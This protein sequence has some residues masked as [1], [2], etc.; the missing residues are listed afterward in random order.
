MKKWKCVYCGRLLG[1]PVGHICKGNMRYRK[2]RFEEGE[3]NDL[4]ECCLAP[5]TA[6]DCSNGAYYKCTACNQP[7]CPV[8]EVDDGEETPADSA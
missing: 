3:M 8:D 1:A 7:C 4:S 6:I 5:M 2:L